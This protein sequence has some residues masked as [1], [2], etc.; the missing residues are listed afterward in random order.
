MGKYGLVGSYMTWAF[1]R[2]GEICWFCSDFLRHQTSINLARLRVGEEEVWGAF[3]APRDGIPREDILVYQIY[4]W[5]LS[6]E[7]F[8]LMESSY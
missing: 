6:M 1:N 7:T 4:T 2:F 5:P 3:N 8:S